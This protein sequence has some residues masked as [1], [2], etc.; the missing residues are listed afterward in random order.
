MIKF[1]RSI[2][3]FFDYRRN[4]I[5]NKLYL[6]EKFGL[7]VSWIYE[8]YTTI[9]LVDVPDEMKQKYGSALPEYEIK[10]YITAVNSNL[11]KLGLEELVNV[12]EI[13]RLNNDEYGIA[14][15]YALF[16][17]ARLFL[18]AFGTLLTVIA[19]IITLIII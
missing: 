14:F 9:T 10:K 2:R 5:E 11:P 18:L 1:F 17:N 15:G 4:I 16:N 6:N 8:M 7:E 3:L 19:S 13:K 12:Y